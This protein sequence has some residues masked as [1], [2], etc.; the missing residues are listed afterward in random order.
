MFLFKKTQKNQNDIQA[1]VFST[2]LKEYIIEYLCIH[3]F[4]FPEVKLQKFDIFA[5][6]WKLSFL[7]SKFF[8]KASTKSLENHYFHYIWIYKHIISDFRV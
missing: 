3:C 1:I 5:I 8:L 6:F 2:L 4:L 7:L